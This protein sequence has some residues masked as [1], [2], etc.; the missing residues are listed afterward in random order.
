MTGAL[1]AA[2]TAALCYGVA[3]VLQALAARRPGAT[4]AEVTRSLPYVVGVGLDVVAF[5]VSTVAL[6]RLPLF[7]VQAIV[8]SSVVVTALLAIP[9]LGVRMRRTEVLAVATVCGGL[10]ML[11]LSA[12]P[13]ALDTPPRWLPV[14]TVVAAGL[15]GLTGWQAVRREVTGPTLAMLAGLSFGMVGLS[16]RLLTAEASWRSWLTDPA[17]YSLVLSGLLALTLYAAALRRWQV[18]SAT[19]VVVA[20]DTI[21]P[22]TVGLIWLGDSAA[23]GRAWL[24]AA[25]FVAALGGALALSRIGAGAYEVES[26]SESEPRAEDGSPDDPVVIERPAREVA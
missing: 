9:L 24:A 25:G 21:V 5:L 10:V 6:R 13:A 22:A 2:L 1:V 8:A 18:T 15:V 11:G 12:S 19:A 14:A 4:L 16:V 17:T 20:L 23:P 26:E 7:S 3:S